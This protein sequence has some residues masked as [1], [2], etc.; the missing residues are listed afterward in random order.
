MLDVAFRED[1]LNGDPD[2]GEG[3]EQIPGESAPYEEGVPR[4]IVRSRGSSRCTA[5]KRKATI[6]HDLVL[7]LRTVRNH[8]SDIFGK[9]LVS[10]RATAIVKARDTRFGSPAH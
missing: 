9:L 8:V 3:D 10:D 2:E 7:S 1:R 5:G 6:A 4:L